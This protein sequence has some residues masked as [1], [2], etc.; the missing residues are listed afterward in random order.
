MVVTSDTTILT[1][2]YQT[3]WWTIGHVLYF[4]FLMYGDVAWWFILLICYVHEGYEALPSVDL[5]T[6]QDG[7]VVDPVQASFGII[8]FLLLQDLGLID[9][10]R[11]LPKLTD[12][13]KSCLFY[14]LSYWYFIFPVSVSL[15]LSYSKDFYGYYFHEWWVAIAF[16]VMALYRYVMDKKS[17]FM[18]LYVAAV[19]GLC[20]GLNRIPYNPFLGTIYFHTPIIIWFGMR[21]LIQLK[22]NYNLAK[23]VAQNSNNMI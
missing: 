9:V 6:I 16:T 19:G 8:T 3:D 21:K 10:I 17:I 15:F 20:V 4:F 1:E 23:A 12:S 2:Q 18:V 11:P 22:E 5:T 13:F 7:L 14:I